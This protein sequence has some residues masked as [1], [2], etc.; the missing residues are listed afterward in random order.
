MWQDKQ[1]LKTVSE[2]C[3]KGEELM[4]K[5]KTISRGKWS[6]Q[7]IFDLRRLRMANLESYTR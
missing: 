1:D 3:L 2:D 5:W 7:S 4:S 6:M